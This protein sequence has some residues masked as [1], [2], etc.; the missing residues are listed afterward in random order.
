M[1]HLNIFQLFLILT[2]AIKIVTGRIITFFNI[3]APNFDDPVF[4]RKVF[5]LIPDLSS[6]HLIAGGDFNTVLDCFLD[7][8]S[9]RPTS[10][11]NASISPS[12]ISQDFFLIVAA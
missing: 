9:T 1:F 10:L 4:F 5:N 11:S 2:A 7:K 12:R 3:Y 8:L 6:T